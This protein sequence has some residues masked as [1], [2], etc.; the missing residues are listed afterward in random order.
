MTDR[1]DPSGF[2]NVNPAQLL[3]DSEGPRVRR[4]KPADDLQLGD[5]DN[6]DRIIVSAG[7]IEVGMV[8][9]EMHV[10]RAPR[11]FEILNNS[12][13]LRIDN[14]HAVGPLAADKNQPGVPGESTRG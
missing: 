7:D 12:V 2:G 6:V 5:V 4:R 8:G 9:V 3:A 10:A 13:G 11:C 14:D 1:D